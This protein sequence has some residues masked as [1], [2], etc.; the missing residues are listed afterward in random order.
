MR[1][2][3]NIL[4]VE[5][6]D[7]NMKL[8]N[9]LLEG[10]GYA[11]TKTALGQEAVK[12]AHETTPD[13]ILLDIQ[14]PDLSGFEVAARL[15]ADPATRAIPIFAV[16][17]FAEPEHEQKALESGCDAYMSKPIRVVDFL[18]KVESFFSD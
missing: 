8:V 3:K 7:L 18:R 9:E 15:K 2:P 11:L 17:A 13:L 16:S 6:N 1:F 14:L 12:I 10:A 4:V 5:D